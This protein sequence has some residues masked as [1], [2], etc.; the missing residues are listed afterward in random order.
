MK[1]ICCLNFLDAD[2]YHVT[3]IIYNDVLL[4]GPHWPD[5]REALQ[6]GITMKHNT[7]SQIVILMRAYSYMLT[8]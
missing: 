7:V 4:V 8:A 2:M 3:K 5:F 6:F 1:T